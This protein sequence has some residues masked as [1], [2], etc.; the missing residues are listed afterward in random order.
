M[1]IETNVDSTDESTQ[2]LFGETENQN[3]MNI[4][5]QPT[6]VIGE[7]HGLNISDGHTQEGTSLPSVDPGQVNADAES[8]P[9][10]EEICCSNAIDSAV[11]NKNENNAPEKLNSSNDDDG[12]FF[13]L[14]FVCL[15]NYLFQVQAKWEL[16]SQ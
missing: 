7:V 3:S 16:L 13:D 6:L 5:Q 15:E 10:L 12:M 8:R 14:V 1:L 4:S 11:E 9:C 2:S